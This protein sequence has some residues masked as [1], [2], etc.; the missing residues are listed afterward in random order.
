MVED[1]KIA[2]QV[3]AFNSANQDYGTYTMGALAKGDI[4]LS[5][6]AE[7]MDEEIKKLQTTID[8]RT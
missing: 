6:L 4:E 1:E 7:V 5:K 8:L 2:F 3:L